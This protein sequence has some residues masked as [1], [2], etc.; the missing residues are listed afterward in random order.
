MDREDLLLRLKSQEHWVPADV[1]G[2]VRIGWKGDVRML[3]MQVN[4]APTALE[5]P[6]EGEW[7]GGR[8]SVWTWTT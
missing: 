6:M 5:F 2:F 8:T 7:Q 3:T 1:K 4:Q